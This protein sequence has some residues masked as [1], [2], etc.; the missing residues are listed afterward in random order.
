MKLRVLLI[1]LISTA[2]AEEQTEKRSARSPQAQIKYN[3][4]NGL[5]V[6]WKYFAP[7]SQW[8]PYLQNP[9]SSQQPQQDHPHPSGLSQ[10]QLQSQL[11]QVEGDTLE[12]RSFEQHQTEPE[13][14][15]VPNQIQ[16]RTYVQPQP[17][18][19]QSDATQPDPN[20]IQYSNYQDPAPSHA[21]QVI[22]QNFKPQNAHPDQSYNSY[23]TGIAAPQQ[24]NQQPANAGL[25][26]YDQSL[27]NYEQEEQ[28]KSR[29]EYPDRS[30]Q[31]RIVYKS[32]Y[33][34]QQ[35]QQQQ[36]QLDRIPVPI[37]RLPSPIPHKLVI[38]KNMPME[39]RQLLQYQARLPYE[40]I[41]NSISYKP[42]SVFVP[43]PLPAETKGPYNYRSKVYYV[44]DDQYETDYGTSKPVEENHRH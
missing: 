44:N 42:K 35:Q 15:Q 27:E 26:Q 1:A 19:S 12:H 28:Q 37:E 4:P 23:P 41:A 29:R 34:E 38:D 25:A 33:E 32:D 22:L 24:Y 43:K 10:E 2:L 7:P 30:L 39:I 18:E 8:R 13:A 36:P 3:D 20:Q 5:K 6:N 16:Y 17:V 40:V 31:G 14:Q 11:V 21:K 9:E